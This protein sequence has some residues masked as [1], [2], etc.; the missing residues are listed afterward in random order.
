MKTHRPTA[1]KRFQARRPTLARLRNALMIAS[2]KAAEAVLFCGTRRSYEAAL[3]ELVQVADVATWDAASF[4]ETEQ[5]ERE[6]EAAM[7]SNPAL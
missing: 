4:A 7:G 1:L 6:L 3:A 2:M 5:E